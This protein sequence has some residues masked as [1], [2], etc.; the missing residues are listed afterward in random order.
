MDALP[1]AVFI[2]GYGSTEV[3]DSATYY[4]VNRR[5]KETDLLPLGKA[6]PNTSIMVLNDRN[7]LAGPDETG[8]LCVRGNNLAY[9]YYNDFERTEKVFVQNPLNKAYHETIYRTGDIVRFN[10]YGEIEYIG[11][12]DFQI[13]HMG[14]RIELGEI[15]VNISSVEGV[16]ENCCLYDAERQKIIV[17]YTGQIEEQNLGEKL[18]QLL[19]VYMCPAQRVHIESMPHNLNGKI[20]RVRLRDELHGQTE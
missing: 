3:T 12:K 2:N 17:F 6:L 19:P 18:K 8:E 11:R 15:E 4:I 9:G 14:H 16:D 7:E 20:D 5:F 1:H 13:K 10:E